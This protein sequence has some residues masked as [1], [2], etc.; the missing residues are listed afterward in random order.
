VLVYKIL[1]PSEW[2]EFDAAGQFG[3]SPLDVSSGFVH[4]SSRAQVSATA[5]RFFPDD[6][7]LVVLAL[8]TDVLGE[9]VRWEPA[10]DG[11]QF[12]HVYGPLPRSAVVAV[13]RVAGATAVE[14]VLGSPDRT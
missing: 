2:E 11:A 4:C 6:P 10:P 3:G 9:A 8:D 7:D 1:L 5:R 12:P 14:E 13:H